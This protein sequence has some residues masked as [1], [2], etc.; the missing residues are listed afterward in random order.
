MK[1]VKDQVF[2][3]RAVLL[4]GHVFEDCLFDECV[5][6][7]GATEPFSLERTVAVNCTQKFVG[8]AQNLIVLLTVM[9]K[10]DE[11]RPAV[12]ALFD[13]IREGNT[14]QGLPTQLEP[15]PSFEA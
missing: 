12:E 3:N 2:K 13:R 7:I 4:D 10:N 14:K 8:P 6:E 1:V 11:Q 9:Y 5:L 15:K